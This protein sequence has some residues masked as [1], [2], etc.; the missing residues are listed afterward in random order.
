MIH[1]V[2]RVQNLLLH[3]LRCWTRKACLSRQTIQWVEVRL[4]LLLHEHHELLL[5]SLVLLLGYLT[6]ACSFSVRH[7]V[8]HLS[9]RLTVLSLWEWR[10]SCK[11]VMHMLLLLHFL[12]LVPVQLSQG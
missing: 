6:L 7:E 5:D 10:L 4:H 11:T 2:L 3:L 8:V 9:G 12:M 1:H